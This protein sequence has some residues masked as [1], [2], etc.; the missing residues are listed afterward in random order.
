M[1]LFLI[2]GTLWSNVATVAGHRHSELRVVTSSGFVNGIYNDSAHTVRAFLGVPYAEP[3][4]QEL[5]WGPPHPK[6]P[7]GRPIDASSFSSPCPQVYTYSNESIYSVLPSMIWNSGDI[8]EDCLYMNIWAPSFEHRGYRG[9]RRATVMMFI[10]GGSYDIGGSS[11]S[12][13]DGT[14]LVQNQDDLIVVT[15]NYRLN[16]FGF[17]NAPD[18]DPSKQNLGI[19]DQRLAI[20]WV[21]ENIARFGGDPDRILLFG[22][23][24]G[25]SSVD[26]HS[27]AY[28]DNPIVSA[29]ALHSGTAPLL[30]TASDHQNWNEL[31]TAIGCGVGAG[32]FQCMRQAPMM[33]IVET[34]TN[35]SYSFCPIVD[36][37][38]VFSD[39][40]ARAKMGK[41]AQLPTLGGSNEREVTAFLPLSQTSVDETTISMLSQKIY[42]CPLRESVRI[43]LSQHVPTWRYL[44]HGNFSNVSPTPWLGAYHGSEV[45]LV[46]GTYDKSRAIPPSARE[47]EVSEYMQGAWVAFAKDPCMGLSEYGWPQFSFDEPTLINIALNNTVEAIFTSASPWDTSCEAPT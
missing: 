45:P 41:L 43:R 9:L 5:R 27:Y 31:S 34:R 28:P 11:V 40:S 16:V 3:P 35:G 44:Y 19:L 29:L 39:Y 18:I 14:N 26:I 47:V 30:T 46:F 4:V 37:V 22:Q 23:S 17:P 1:H 21:Y 33:K 42:N 38:L 13:Y 15:F 32:S 8:S 7:P 6:S 20:E 2:L 12:Y 25:A 10:H 24:T 36:N